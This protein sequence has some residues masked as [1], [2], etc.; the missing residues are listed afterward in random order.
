MKIKYS[1][2]ERLCSLTNK[3]IDF[4]LY[5]AQYQNDAGLIR[6]I[7]Y[8][9]VV[10]QCGMCKQSFYDSLRSLDK[11]GIIKYS[12]SNQ[13]YD[14]TILGNDF[15]YKGSYSEGY[16]NINKSVF[17]SSKFKQLRAKEKLL[18]LLFMKVT[19][20]N[21]GSYQ[22][23]TGKFYK[24]YMELLGVTMRI[25]RGYLHSLRY[26]FSVGRKNGKYFITYL[27]KLK[28]RQ[29]KSETDQY[30]EHTI[31]MNCRRNKVNYEDIV[32]PEKAIQ[33]TATVLKQY[34]KVAQEQGKDILD[35][36]SAVIK[37]MSLLNSKL[38]HKLIRSTLALD[39][40]VVH[41]DLY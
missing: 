10:E 22:I 37:R 23:K 40:G 30:L 12:R 14:I 34:R 36:L 1:L 33:D 19:H 4:L 6:G 13:D 5:V 28:P 21:V 39:P 26:F 38:V 9:D 25:L 3:E 31:K 27:A 2:L 18:M 11:Q 17:K 41:S 24:K 16:V 7:Y 15:S 20:E 35:V 8:R 29:E 32:N